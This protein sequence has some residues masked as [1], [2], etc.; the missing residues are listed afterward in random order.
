MRSAFLGTSGEF[1]VKGYNCF[2]P[3]SENW[4]KQPDREEFFIPIPHGNYNL[5]IRVRMIK[6]LIGRKGRKEV[7]F[8]SVGLELELD[9]SWYIVTRHCNYHERSEREFHTHNPKRLPVLKSK[10]KIK[11]RNRMKIPGSQL[12]WSVRNITSN[13]HI[14]LKQYLEKVGV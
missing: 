9:N 1:C 11:Q 12:R 10:R 5:Q 4:Y 13:Y 7:K 8:F 6:K 14:Y 3:K 2:V